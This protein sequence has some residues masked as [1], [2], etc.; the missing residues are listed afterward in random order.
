[1]VQMSRMWGQIR[2]YQWIHSKCMNSTDLCFTHTS[3][4]GSASLSGGTKAASF[5]LILANILFASKPYPAGWVPHPT[6]LPELTTPTFH[7][8]ITPPT[9]TNWL[10]P[11]SANQAREVDLKEAFL[12][13]LMRQ[14]H[15]GV[16]RLE[17]GDRTKKYN[18]RLDETQFSIQL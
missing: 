4:R 8:P 10:P 18:P 3:T 5:P 1:M 11:S 13:E 15:V 2:R 14:P 12:F 17:P 7:L 6:W 16:W 9:S